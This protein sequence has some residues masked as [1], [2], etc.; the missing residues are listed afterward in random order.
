MVS[1]SSQRQGQQLDTTKTKIHDPSK[2]G[3]K[4]LNTDQCANASKAQINHK[5][6]PLKAHHKQNQDLLLL[7]GNS[8]IK[9]LK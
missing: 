2:K 6:L 1:L 9:D 8:D 4:G 5:K 3:R 7:V